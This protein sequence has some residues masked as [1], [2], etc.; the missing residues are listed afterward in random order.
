MKLARATMQLV[1][2]TE[3]CPFSAVLALTSDVALDV[4]MDALS[5]V[6]SC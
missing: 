3:T 5:T 1:E 2:A 4:A 6:L